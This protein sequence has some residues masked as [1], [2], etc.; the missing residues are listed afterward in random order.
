M[1]LRKRTSR[2][3]WWLGLWFAIA[4]AFQAGL[5]AQFIHRLLVHSHGV[6]AD[7]VDWIFT[8]VLMVVTPLLCLSLGFYAAYQRPWDLR[9]W[10]LLLLLISYALFVIGT[11]TVDAV[12]SWPPVIRSLALVYRTFWF[13]SWPVWMIL[14]AIN[15]PERAG[16]D[17]RWPWLKLI[18]LTPVG[19]LGAL[20]MV[21]RIM[22]NEGVPR[23]RILQVVEPMM[24][25]V[26]QNVFWLTIAICQ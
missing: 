21:I 12:M 16:V 13:Y 26:M 20:Y 4:L 23:P 15:F 9:A 24:P 5:A 1:P 19:A 17:R 25:S 7:A 8:F 18:V 10:L 22:R 3:T 6:H 14:F 11:D 2:N